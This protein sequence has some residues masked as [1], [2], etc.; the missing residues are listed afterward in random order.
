MLEEGSGW[1]HCWRCSVSIC[2]YL[3]S[4]MGLEEGE[5]S[6]LCGQPSLEVNGVKGCL[7]EVGNYLSAVKL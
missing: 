7:L 2:S 5:G 1:I 4:E 3:S 6:V